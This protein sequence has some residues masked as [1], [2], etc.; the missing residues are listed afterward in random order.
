SS[1]ASLSPTLP[2]RSPFR[3]RDSLQQQQQQ[4]KAS[5]DEPSTIYT[6]VSSSS[7]SSANTVDDDLTHELQNIW[8]LKPIDTAIKQE[9]I[10][11]DS[12]DMLMQLLVSH[13]VIDSKEYPILSF[14]EYEQLKQVKQKETALS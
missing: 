10:Q 14:E 6:S 11:I 1:Q 2:T 9:T 13:A 8:K 5:H 12:E 7:S 4:I 3:I